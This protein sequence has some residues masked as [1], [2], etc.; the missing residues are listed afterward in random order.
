MKGDLLHVDVARREPGPR[1]LQVEV[2]HP[3]ERL[4][5][6]E[7]AD[8]VTRREERVVP[9]LQR[10]RRS[11]VPNDSRSQIRSVVSA[12]VIS[13]IAVTEGRNP[14]GKMY[15]LIQVKVLPGRQHPVVRHRDRLDADAAAGGEQA[16][17]GLE[18]RRP[19]L[20]PTASIISTE[21]MASKLPCTSR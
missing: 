11:A 1:V 14:P 18:V 10:L 13:S 8:L 20:V 5:E 21:T 6:A 4:V 16:V 9:A 7:R 3:A 15:L 2:P 17:D 12:R 19:E